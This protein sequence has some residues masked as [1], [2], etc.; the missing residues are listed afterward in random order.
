MAD[1]ILCEEDS[2]ESYSTSM[3]LLD[4]LESYFGMEG[5]FKNC[6]IEK[7]ESF[8]NKAYR[9]YMVSRAYEAQLGHFERSEKIYGPDLNDYEDS[10]TSGTCF[11]PR[12]VTPS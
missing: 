7:L 1:S 10:E 12:Y 3:T 6:T 9:R 8:A 11:N 2:D 4:I 5:K